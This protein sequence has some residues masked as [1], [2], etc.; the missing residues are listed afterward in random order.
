M[1][2]VISK[3]K[4]ASFILFLVLV[5]TGC[6]KFLDKKPDKAL[7]VPS[8]VTDLQALLD[9]GNYMNLYVNNAYGEAGADNYYLT[10]D[11]WTTLFY[12]TDKNAYLW[13]ADVTSDNSPNDWA[14]LYRV[15]YYANIVL[16]TIHNIQGNAGNETE[17]NNIKGSALFYRGQSFHTLALAWAKAYDP[18]TASSDPGIPLRMNSD[19]NETSVRASVQQTYDQVISDLQLAIPLLPV[20][21]KHTMR[22]SKTA[23]YALLSRVYLSMR[24]Y[25]KALLYADSCLQLNNKLLNYNTLVPSAN[26]PFAAFNDETLFYMVGAHGALIQSK[27][28]ID[29]LLYSSYSGNDLRKTL[30][31]KSNGDGSYSF[32]GAYTGLADLFVGL[33]TDEVY[34]TKAECLARAGNTAAAMITLNTLLKT[35]WK[36]GSFTD[37]TASDAN[38]ALQIILTERRKE[39]LLRDLR[40]MDIKRL[41]KE[42]ANIAITRVL[43]GQVYTL[44]PNDNRF[45]LSI[46]DYV[47]QLSGMPQN[48][49]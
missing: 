45:A 42:G 4:I 20:T 37:F 49:R 15:V 13:E 38:E 10:Y 35:R 24:L 48:P 32:K 34:L 43:N 33:A 11:R 47:I 9:N 25:D 21:P 46:P 28:R 44:L 22:P 30:F 36:T 3:L 23:A 18:A 41:N 29:S 5:A 27:E 14:T 8:S 40:W 39:L 2:P 7:A 31:F 12:Q 6:K 16:E 17:G 26:F 19:F 1:N